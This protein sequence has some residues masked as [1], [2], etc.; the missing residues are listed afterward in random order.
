M[1]H[2]REQELGRATSLGREVDDAKRALDVVGAGDHV[3][4][5]LVVD[6]GDHAPLEDESL[7]RFYAVLG[8]VEGHVDQCLEVEHSHLGLVVVGALGKVRD[9]ALLGRWASAA[10]HF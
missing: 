4:A 8:G 1:V 6:V 9:R 5:W 7:K 2:E 10:P 3:L